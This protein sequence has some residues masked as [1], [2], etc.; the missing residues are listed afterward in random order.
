MGSFFS[1]YLQEYEYRIVSTVMKWLITETSIMKHPTVNTEYS[2]GSYE[3]D[4]IKLLK[5][6]VDAYEGGLSKLLEDLNDKTLE[7]TSFEL[8]W[9]CKSID[10]EV[11]DLSAIE[12]L[13]DSYVAEIKEMNDFIVMMGD[14]DSDVRICD[15]IQNILKP[16]HYMFLLE[17]DEK[18]Y[19]YGWDGNRWVKNANPLRHCIQYEI[20]EFFK[21]KLTY[22]QSI[23]QSS[24]ALNEE[25]VM[26]AFDDVENIR[27]KTLQQSA[28]INAIVAVACSVLQ[29][30]NE[31]VQ[32]DM[33]TNLLGMKNGVYD[34]SEK[35][36]RPYRFDDYV[37]YS[38]GY[39]FTPT[40][41][42][43]NYIVK[44]KIEGKD[45]LQDVIKKAESMPEGSDE[46]QNYLD[47]ANLL[48]Q[49]FPDSEVRNLM[50][51]IISSGLIGHI[52]N[53]FCFNGSGGN[54]KGVL[55][56]F[57]ASTLG[58]YY[59]DA[60]NKLII[61]NTSDQDSSKPNSALCQLDKKR[62]V[63]MK[64]L[65]RRALL[66]NSAIKH[67]TGG[68]TISARELY[69]KQKPI[70][71]FMTLVCE[72]NEKPDFNE[73]PT[74]ADIRRYVDILF[75]SKFVTDESLVDEEKH[76]YLADLS[77][78]ETQWKV[79]RRNA[80]LNVLIDKANQLRDKRY[81]FDIPQC[82]E[83]RTACY[84]NSQYPIYAIFLQLFEE[85]KPDNSH[86]Y[87]NCKNEVKDEDWI[88]KDVVD[89]IRHSSYFCELKPNVKKT[90]EKVNSI[91]DFFESFPPLSKL[92]YK[93]SKTQKRY[94]KNW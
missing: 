4:G 34:F 11:Y 29:K 52:E 58:D 93:D 54:G 39:D 7:L 21:Q 59:L 2:V 51:Q 15:F 65:P 81:K 27:K 84:M 48:H 44:E 57:I 19:W 83:D 10:D 56:E 45:E 87:K 20:Y 30:T 5:S 86:L 91:K 62:Y 89:H 9:E 38:V 50:L 1:L 8:K 16:N 17:S 71:L 43:I 72:V 23:I 32:F 79:R 22:Y 61:E 40:F 33:N 53:F 55:N 42:S 49:L 82:V 85:R 75:G 67:L 12:P 14:L 24:D 3:Y 26:K 68:G 64:E 46:W 92:L 77:I 37:T 36:F 41:P 47:V 35:V 13:P 94:I 78:K 6:N 66:Q 88:F 70:H 25:I 73:E 69:G 80:F 28:G 63:V 18:G 60:S 31:E 76:I 90:Y 74:G